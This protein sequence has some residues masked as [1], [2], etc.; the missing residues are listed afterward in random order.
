MTELYKYLE[1]LKTIGTDGTEHNYRTPF[2]NLLNEIK[3]NNYI[4]IIHE[5]RRKEGFGAPDFLV[6][7]SGAIIGY[8]ETKQIGENL[9]KTLKTAQLKR[10]LSISDNLIL[11]NYHDF[12]LIKDNEILER[13]TLCYS[14]DIE[15]AG[16]KLDEANI[17]NVLRLFEKFFFSEPLKISN[18]KKLATSLAIRGR[19]LK[20]FIIEIFKQDNDDNFTIRLKGLHNTFKT[21]LVEDLEVKEFSDA[22]TQTVIYGY[23][24]AHLQTDG[25]IDLE[26][27]AKLIPHSFEVIKEFF[28]IINYDDM[29]THIHWIFK[30]IVNLINNTDMPRIK[31]NLSFET[32]KDPYLYFYEDFLGEFDAKK[33]KSRGVYYTPE[34]VVSFITRSINKILIEKFNKQDGFIDSSVTVLDFAIG[35]GTFLVMI[36][37]LIF[38]KIDKNDGR[39]TKI[40]QDHILKNF[41]G[42]EY[43][44]APYAVCHLKLSQLLKDKGYDLKKDERFNVYLADT[45]DDAEPQIDLHMP[46]ISREGEKALKIKKEKDILVITG[47]PPYNSKSRNNKDWITELNKIYKPKDEKNVQPLNDDYIKFIR[48]AHWKIEQNGKGVFGFISNNSFING[49]I[50]RKMRNELLK[51]FDEIYILNLHGNSRIG[52]NA[53]DGGIDQ[54]VFDIMQGVSINI[55]VKNETEDQNEQCKIYYSDCFGKREQ[56]Y[57]F[58]LANDINSVEWKLIDYNDFNDEFNKTRWAA[59]RFEDNL[60]FFTQMNDVDLIKDYGNFW[61]ITEIFENYKSGIQT[62]NDNLFI[63]FDFQKASKIYDDMSKLDVDDFKIK[64]EFN[65]SDGWGF[66]SKYKNLEYLKLTDVY[67]RPFDIR[68]IIYS[69][70]LRRN[71]NEIMQHFLKEDNVGLCFIRNDY[72]AESF[73]FFSVTDKLIDIHTI[74]GQSYIAPLYLY[75]EIEDDD[76]FAKETHLNKQVNFTNEFVKFINE[77]YSFKPTPEEI[78]GYIYAVLHSPTYRE[79]YLELLKIDF[80]RVPF[81]DNEEQFK[82]LAELGT[83]LIEHHL[84]KKTYPDNPIKLIGKADQVNVETINYIEEKIQINPNLYFYPVKP[85]VWDFY[86]GGYKV[87]EHWLKSRKGRELSYQEIEHFIKVCNVIE[88]TVMLMNDIDKLGLKL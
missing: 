79:K 28:N 49:L 57:E 36:F 5:P 67:Y 52:E 22:F 80:P 48:Y 9:D 66:E 62:G 29:P 35:T 38:E 83:E 3:P 59:K 44:V 20:E 4:K 61:G 46:V 87:L 84:L 15:K 86:I 73:N 19:T 25:D 68:N 40:I 10:Y 81:I 39:F 69:Y 70:A 6:E 41:Y 42:F 63:K 8:I 13:A 47:N 75:N 16:S 64:Y 24:L 82:K 21:S 26:D 65:P 58:L 37:N 72:G 50:H 32:S 2:E 85:E 77:K 51:C 71:S 31:K 18:S 23:F 60:S 14:T 43:L 30:E 33:R 45:L 11:T 88:K 12:I 53:P 78:I 56:K 34:E 55:F 1:D 7:K 54:N 74:G 76:L 27:G 17:K